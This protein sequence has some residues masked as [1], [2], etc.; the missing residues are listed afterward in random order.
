MKKKFAS[1]LLALTCILGLGVATR[2]S[3][4]DEIVVTLPFE[5]VASGKTLPAGTYKLRRVSDDKLSGQVLSNDHASVF[6]KAFTVA[7]ASSGKPQVSFVHVGEQHFL[8]SIRTVDDVYS[9][10]VP[11][12]EIMEAA[13]RQLRQDSTAGT[14]GGN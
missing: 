13:A 10:S 9:I 11:R 8:C 5:F 7:R 14:S 12:A 6:V 3:T 4:R 1:I 2:A